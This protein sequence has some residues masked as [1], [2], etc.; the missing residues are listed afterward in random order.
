MRDSGEMRKASWFFYKDK[1]Y[2]LGADGKML[3]NTK[4]PDGYYVDGSGVWVN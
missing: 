4:T 1:W 3:I 2:Y